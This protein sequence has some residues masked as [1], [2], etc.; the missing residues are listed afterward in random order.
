MEK[1][2][3]NQWDVRNRKRMGKMMKNQ[4]KLGNGQNQGGRCG[5]GYPENSS[6]DK[7]SKSLRIKIL[8][9][10]KIKNLRNRTSPEFLAKNGNFQKR[11]S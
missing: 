11:E 10:Q 3:L 6:F 5:M 4:G 8:K 7:K 9:N 2:V 1:L